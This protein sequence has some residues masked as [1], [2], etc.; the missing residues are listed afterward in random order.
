MASDYGLNFGFRRSD[1]SVRVSEGR[2]KTP[3]SGSA[4]LLG[5][6]VTI[7]TASPGY[8]KV[9]TASA[10]PLTGVTGLLVQEE[11]WDR[12]IYDAQRVDSFVLGVAKK[13]RLSVITNGPGVKIWLKN[14]VQQDRVDGRTIPAVT[15]FTATNVAVGRGLAWD[16]TYWVDVADPTDATCHMVVT[17]YNSTAKYLEAVLTH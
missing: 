10:K 2:Y 11:V 7:N 4:L 9:A 12:S 1:E 16:G 13:N 17:E 14:T 5:T 3:A 6:C 8:L 15:M